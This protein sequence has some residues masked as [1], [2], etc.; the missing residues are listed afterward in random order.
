MLSAEPSPAPDAD[1][2]F[3][4][5]EVHARSLGFGHADKFK[6]RGACLGQRQ[7]L[8]S[9]GGLRRLESPGLYHRNGGCLAGLGHKGRA[10][11]D[12]PDC[13]ERVALADER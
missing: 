3:G 1:D 7:C 12:H 8:G 11:I 2:A 9:P 13:R 6:S 5:G 4:G 10:A